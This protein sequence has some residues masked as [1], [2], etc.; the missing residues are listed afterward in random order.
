M[1]QPQDLPLSSPTLIL[2][3][4]AELDALVNFGKKCQGVLVSCTS[5]VSDL[6]AYR[7]EADKQLKDLSDSLAIEQAKPKL[8]LLYFVPPI[9][10]GLV[11]GILIKK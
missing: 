11:L 5:R 8:N 9:V 2:V 6:E 7:M 1:D 3:E 4:Q 10:V